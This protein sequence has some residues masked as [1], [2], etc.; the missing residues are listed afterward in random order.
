MQARRA[1]P[2]LETARFRLRQFCEGDLDAYARITGDAETMRFMGRDGALSREQAWCSLGYLL[3]HWEIRGFGLWAVEE[4]ASGALV[5]RVGLYRPEG[6]PGLEVGWLVDRARWGEG[7][8]TETARASL[9]HAFEQLAPDRV[10]SVILPGNTASIRVAEKL[11]ERRVESRKLQGH[12]VA[13]YAI[14]RDE[15]KPSAKA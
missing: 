4:K 8:A 2:E 1:R 3:G 6:W 5:G 15:W 7:I 10:I 12:D 11:G 13:I 14:G 9:D